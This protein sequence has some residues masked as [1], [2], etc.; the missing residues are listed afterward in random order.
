[1]VFV[2]VFPTFLPPSYRVSNAEKNVCDRRNWKL[3]RALLNMLAS[4]P[5][6]HS[7][8]RSSYRHDSYGKRRKHSK[9]KVSK[10]HVSNRICHFLFTYIF[11]K[12]WNN[13]SVWKLHFYNFFVCFLLT[14]EFLL[15]VANYIST[16]L[17]FCESIKGTFEGSLCIEIENEERKRGKLRKKASQR[18]ERISKVNLFWSSRRFWAAFRVAISTTF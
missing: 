17:K 14:I 9:S 6:G 10:K 11:H 15:W 2:L 3:C 8:F 5:N 4:N 7:I 16:P 13:H 1:M 18:N 12:I